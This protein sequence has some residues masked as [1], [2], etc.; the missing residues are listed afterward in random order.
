MF[1]IAAFVAAVLLPISALA[2]PISVHNTGVDGS[3]VLVAAGAPTAFWTLLSEPGGA[4][5]AIGSNPYRYYNGAYAAD[6]GVSAWV[7][8]TA[9]GNAGVGGFYVYQLLVDLTGFD[10][11]TVVVTGLFGTDND[12]FIDVNGG[13]AAA[14]QGFAG[15]GSLTS[16]TLNSGFV[17]GV[18]SIQIAV[19]NGGDPTAIRAEFLRADATPTNGSP[20]PE[21]ASMLLLGTGLIGG[22]RRWRQR[23][24]QT[25]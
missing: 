17:A 19:D 22:V 12:G 2:S 24:Q 23:R 20:V 4:S 8:P 25:A 18:N 13:P 11:S 7:A 9:S 16:F 3:D 1:R 5:E 21:P 10:P 15:F 6:D 14:S